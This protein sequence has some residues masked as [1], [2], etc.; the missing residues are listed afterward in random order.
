MSL[1][2]GK[3]DIFKELKEKF[4]STYMVSDSP[5]IM[6]VSHVCVCFVWS[7]MIGFIFWLKNHRCI[8]GTVILLYLYFFMILLS[9]NYYIYS[10]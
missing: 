5:L 10:K 4:K 2:E 1:M 3:E 8:L 6:I 7:C 9:R